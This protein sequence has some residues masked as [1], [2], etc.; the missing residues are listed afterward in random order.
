MTKYTS[1]ARIARISFITDMTKP[2]ALEIPL[3][4]MLEAA[5]PDRARW[6]G[7]IGRTKLTG[8]EISAVNLLTWPQLER[9]FSL[10]DE[11]FDQGW[12]GPWG[13]ACSIVQTKWGMSPV[14][15]LATN[16]DEVLTGRAIDS[17]AA[18]TSMKTFL[19]DELSK[20]GE[21]LTPCDLTSIQMPKTHT[22]PKRQRHPI[23]VP[24]RRSMVQE[25]F[26]LAA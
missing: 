2:G 12:E 18:W 11:M 26:A 20:L 1:K 23:H 4:Y 7:L 5:W 16:Y 3:G 15:A 19:C 6:L 9:P 24:P 22:K 8:P 25:D 10:L 13:D 17:D 14:M 21:K